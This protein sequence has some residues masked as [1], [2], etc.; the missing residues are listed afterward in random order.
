M[1]ARLWRELHPNDSVQLQL[2]F[3]QVAKKDNP[4]GLLEQV[5]IT[6]LPLLPL[7]D[8]HP[9]GLS[10]AFAGLEESPTLPD[11]TCKTD[12]KSELL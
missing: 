6:V 5:S 2:A 8:P 11:T 10:A 12:R 7:P 9:P 4:K 3:R 1:L